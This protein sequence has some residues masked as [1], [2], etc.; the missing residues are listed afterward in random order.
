MP[1]LVPTCELSRM[2]MRNN[3]IA[4][5]DRHQRLLGQDSVVMGGKNRTNGIVPRMPVSVPHLERN[6]AR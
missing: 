5:Q 1:Q 4:K 2:G 3:G 6:G